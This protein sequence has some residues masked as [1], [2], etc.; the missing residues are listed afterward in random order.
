MDYDNDD[1]TCRQYH[2]TNSCWKLEILRGALRWQS[3]S[4][5][6]KP[7]EVLNEST[8]DIDEKDVRFSQHWHQSWDHQNNSEIVQCF[9]IVGRARV[10][11]NDDESVRFEYLRTNID[12]MFRSMTT[13]W[14][15]C[16]VLL[17][18]PCQ[19]ALK[20]CSSL[21]RDIPSQQT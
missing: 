18:C 1:K 6:F 13:P 21:V 12:T 8:T 11:S 15:F 5:T 19:T 16:W 20:D 14:Q 9:F 3:S 2:W 7:R 4:W 17:H 10:H